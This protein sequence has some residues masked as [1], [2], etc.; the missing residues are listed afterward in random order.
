MIDRL[1]KRIAAWLARQLSIDRDTEEVYQY[2]LNL[3]LLNLLEVLLILLI[4]YLLNTFYTTLIVLLVFTVFRGVGGGAH[5][6]TPARCLLVGTVQIVVLGVI[7][8]IPV[9]KTILS[10]LLLGTLLFNFGVIIKWVPGG[11][12]KKPLSEPTVR[13]RAKLIS[14]IITFSWLT[15]TLGLVYTGNIR[16]VLA[17]ILGSFSA[18]FLVTP[19]GYRFNAIL[20]VKPNLSKGGEQNEVL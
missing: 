10:F 2:G 17:M 15:V 7:A 9:N 3:L 8:A 14:F 13:R 20:D 12:E 19:T 1:S 16:Y 6:S 4:S 18:M 11:T 5:M